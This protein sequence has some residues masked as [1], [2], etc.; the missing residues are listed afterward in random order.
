M[1]IAPAIN[2]AGRQTD[3]HAAALEWPI[4]MAPAACVL[5]DVP[6]RP[7]RTRRYVN[8]LITTHRAQSAIIDP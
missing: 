7:A 1:G 8:M 4:A 2:R 3:A 5:F 6:E